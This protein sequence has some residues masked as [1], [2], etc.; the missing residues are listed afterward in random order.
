MT[1]SELEALKKWEEEF[2]RKCRHIKLVRKLYFH[3][4]SRAKYRGIKFDISLKEWENWWKDQ[5]G[6]DWISKRGNRRGKYV[7]A[8]I[9]DQ[10]SYRLGNIKC[11]LT[12]ENVKEVDY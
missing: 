10:G 5:L 9:G 1:P 2:E 4:K 6:P 12:E 7:M 11:I 8:R 3:H